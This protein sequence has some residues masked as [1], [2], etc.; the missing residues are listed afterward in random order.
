MLLDGVYRLC[1]GFNRLGTRCQN[2]ANRVA[3]KL[4]CERFYARVESSGKEERL[5]EVRKLC[6]DPLDCGQE[7]HVQHAVRFVQYE[8]AY[9]I[10][11]RLTLPDEI[12]EPPR[13][14]D[15]D[16]TFAAKRLNLTSHADP[17]INRFDSDFRVF[18]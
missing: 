14:C 15:D 9:S 18:R 12:A 13:R 8:D 10:Q 3:Q 5:T 6:D 2:H 16:F 7:A 17:A 1:N 4:V 11:L